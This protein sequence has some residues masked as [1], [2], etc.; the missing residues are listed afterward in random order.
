MSVLFNTLHRFIRAFLPR[1]RHLL[2]SWLDS[3]CTVIL[4]PQKIK[5]VT[6]ST[7]SPSICHEVMK[8]RW[9]MVDLKEFVPVTTLFGQESFF[10]A[11]YL[12]F[13]A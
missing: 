5:R 4:E 13:L 12:L 1:S 9:L 2:I 3:L 11:L 10:S 8:V 7:F 6:T